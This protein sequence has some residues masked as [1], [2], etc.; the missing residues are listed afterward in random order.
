MF[1][2]NI[3]ENGWKWLKVQLDVGLV[4]PYLDLFGFSLKFLMHLELDCTWA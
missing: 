2:F 3:I 1:Y 4:N